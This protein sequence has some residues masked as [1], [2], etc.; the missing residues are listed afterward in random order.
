MWCNFEC[1]VMSRW[2]CLYQPEDNCVA[3]VGLLASSRLDQ[4]SSSEWPTA[5]FGT[6]LALTLD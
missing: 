5:T 1:S 4:I 6:S 2:A 3:Q